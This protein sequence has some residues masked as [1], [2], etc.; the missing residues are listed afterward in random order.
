MYKEDNIFNRTSIRIYKT[1]NKTTIVIPPLY[2]WKKHK[3]KI[4]CFLFIYSIFTISNFASILCC[5]IYGYLNTLCYLASSIFDRKSAGIFLNI[6]LILFIP[7]LSII[8]NSGSY[9]LILIG[10]LYLVENLILGD[11]R[12]ILIREVFFATYIEIEATKYINIESYKFSISKKIRYI[13]QLDLS[14]K[15]KIIHKEEKINPDFLM[16]I[17]LNSLFNRLKILCVLG[18]KNSQKI[19]TY[20]LLRNR[21]Y[22]FGAW[23]SEE[24]KKSLS[25]II[26]SQ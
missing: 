21:T 7:I 14:V 6:Q 12:N 25:N 17:N 20:C 23:F 13:W 24:E 9:I 4:Y 10:S 5:G 8:S 18:S 22:L 2:K 26:K 3:T 15:E 1:D 11:I 16:T 19:D